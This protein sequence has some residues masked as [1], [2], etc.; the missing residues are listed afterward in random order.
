MKV[1]LVW[2]GRGLKERPFD[3]RPK[4]YTLDK[5]IERLHQCGFVAGKGY[6]VRILDERGEQLRQ[7]EDASNQTVIQALRELVEEETLSP[8]EQLLAE[9]EQ[10]AVEIGGQR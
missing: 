8:A 10:L 7:I 2:E 4:L 5:A 9:L 1:Q 6:V 3:P